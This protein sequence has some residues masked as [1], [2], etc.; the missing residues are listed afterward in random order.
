MTNNTLFADS[1]LAVNSACMI[2]KAENITINDSNFTNNQATEH[3]SCLY[4]EVDDMAINNNSFI[5]NSNFKSDLLDINPILINFLPKNLKD[6]HEKKALERDQLFV[7]GP[8]NVR[9]KYIIVKNSNF[10]NNY[11]TFGG[12]FYL[13]PQENYNVIIDN[14]TFYSNSAIK[15]GG[16]FCFDQLSRLIGNV[17]ISNCR[18]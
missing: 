6:L 14:S 9:F 8:I 2:I 16:V 10:I 17:Y 7:Y 4:L 11:A 1:Y 15:Y 3:S 13:K 5:E 12:V 18:N